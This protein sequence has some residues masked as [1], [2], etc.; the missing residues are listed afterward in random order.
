MIIIENVTKE[1]NVTRLCVLMI[2]GTFGM[3][4]ITTNGE[5]LSQNASFRFHPL[6]K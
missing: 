6:L 5:V 3:L 2:T 4:Q 1:L